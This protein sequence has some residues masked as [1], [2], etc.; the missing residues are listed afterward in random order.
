MFLESPRGFRDPAA[1][2]ARLELLHTAETVQ[3]LIEWSAE[4]SARRGGALVPHFDPADAGVAARVMILHEAPGPMTNADNRRPG[5]GFISI[6]NDDRSAETEWHARNDAG[7]HTGLIHWNIVPWYLGPASVKPNAVELG[8]GGAALR[9]LLALL[10]D[11]R[12]VVLSGRYA[13]TGWKKHVA[14]FI[15]SELRVVET[16]HPSPLAM[17]QPGKREHYRD[18][19]ARIAQYAR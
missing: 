17:N 13:Q 1:V 9:S 7:M 4:L 16:W 5:S 19:M 18:T 3:P 8:H 6:D 12:A 15:R 14:P 11:L 10:P 2:A